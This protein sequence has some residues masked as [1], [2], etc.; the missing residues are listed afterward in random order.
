[1]KNLPSRRQ[2]I[3]KGVVTTAALAGVS[4]IGISRASASPK[5]PEPARYVGN[6]VVIEKAQKIYSSPENETL[7]YCGWPDIAFWRGKYYVIFSRKKGHSA[8]PPDGPGLV[9][10]ESTD[11]EN[12]SE[13]VLKD[14]SLPHGGEKKGDD[15]DAKVFATPD[16]LFA[17]NIPYPHDGYISYTEDGV[18]WSAWRQI[19][20]AGEGIQ[21]RD[22]RVSAVQ[23]YGAQCW[24]PKEYNG[25]YYLPCDY[26]NDRVDLL[27]STD[28]LNWQLA[29]TIMSRAK[30]EHNESPTE[31]EIVFLKDGRCLALTRMR[32]TSNHP[33]LPSFS[34]SSPPYSSWDFKFGTAIPFGG[35]AAHRFGDT[36]LVIARAQ[37]GKGPGYWNFPLDPGWKWPQRTGVYTFDLE[38]MRLEQQV[39]LP[40]EYAHDSSYAGILP[41]GANTALI[42]WY[43][44]NVVDTSNIWL[45]HLKIVS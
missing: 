6:K 13:T 34:I 44:G 18:N 29:G 26:Y 12:W 33:E 1:M 39:L 4:K 35:P 40:T 36:I 37:L 11:L 5:K 23:T 14:F 27:K 17:I 43:D 30:Y 22:I 3:K 41:T 42:V 2:F 20:P 24:R 7:K 28:M 15:R 45:A 31:T 16:R 25:T 21:G 10:I 32:P 8:E 9:V 19:Y 38:E